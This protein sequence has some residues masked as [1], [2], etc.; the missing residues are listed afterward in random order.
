[1]GIK[2]IQITVSR[3]FSKTDRYPSLIGEPNP[4]DRPNSH[5]EKFLWNPC[6][7]VLLSTPKE[8]L[9]FT[10]DPLL[11]HWVALSC[12][13]PALNESTNDRY[14]NPMGEPNPKNRP[15]RWE[16]LSRLSTTTLQFLD[17][18]S[19]HCLPL[20]KHHYSLRTLS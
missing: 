20:E 8:T 13:T 2:S 1:M 9:S 17:V 3:F 19:Y 11:G 16:N 6:R 7:I 18:G 12:Y 10:P 15:H 14:P 5:T 4:K